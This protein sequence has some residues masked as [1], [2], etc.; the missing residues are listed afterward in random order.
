[1]EGFRFPE[2]FSLGAASAATQ[3]DGDCKNSNWYDWY[4]K[5]HVI[6]GSDP[7]VA[8]MHRKFLREDTELMASMGIRHYRFGLEWARIEPEEG[9]FS[10]G[11]FDKVREEI[12]LLRE[13][14]IA[15]LLTIHHFSNPLWF[16]EKG[17]FLCPDSP[18]IFL[19]LTQKV[20]ERLA[21]FFLVCEY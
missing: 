4:Q 12:L 17:G 14:G 21:R 6:D 2:H 19:R 10:D 15:T 7:D 16:E 3:V 11:E 8:T 9:V 13:K 1:M 5:G 20:V 18:E